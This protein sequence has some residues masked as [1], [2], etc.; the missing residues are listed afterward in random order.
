MYK[1]S[2]S[3][4]FHICSLTN[5]KDAFIIILFLMISYLNL[6]DYKRVDILPELQSMNDHR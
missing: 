2:S 4:L 3:N 6:K 1:I 5:D